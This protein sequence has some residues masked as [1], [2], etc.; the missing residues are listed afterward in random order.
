MAFSRE[1]FYWDLKAFII[2]MAFSRERFY[3]D[4]KAFKSLLKSLARPSGIPA[5]ITSS[6]TLELDLFISLKS[7]RVHILVLYVSSA[8]EILFFSSIVEVF[9]LF[10]VKKVF[11]ASS[12]SSKEARGLDICPVN[13]III[14]GGRNWD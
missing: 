4:L 1:R 10:H 2:N 8:S 5:S 7:S 11:I 3:W 12:S 9:S 14:I 6:Y 13:S